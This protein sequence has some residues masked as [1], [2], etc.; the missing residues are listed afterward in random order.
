MLAAMARYVRRQAAALAA[1][2]RRRL[3]AGEVEFAAAA[4]GG[5]RM[6]SMSS[7]HAPEFSRPIELARLAR[8]RRSIEIAAEPAER[9]A[10][11]ER[12]DLLALDR[13]EAEVR[14]RRLAGEL[15]QAQRPSSPPM[16]CRPASSRWSR[17]KPASTERFTLLYG[18]GRA[19]AMRCVI[20]LDDRDRR[21][22]STDGASISARRWP[23]SSR[24]RSTPIPA[25][26]APA[27]AGTR[28]SRRRPRPSPALAAL[29]EGLT[30]LMAMVA[31]QAD[32]WLL[33][34]GPSRA[35]L[36]ACRVHSHG[37]SEEEDLEVAPQ[38]A[39]R[40]TMR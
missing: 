6:M 32:F 18:A 3:L 20:D 25:P 28:R 33:T 37:R 12:F 10:L 31:S 29:N 9:A 19:G 16:W 2:P 35:F 15:V 22:A 23:S 7:R 39:P 8:R 30:G 14:L 13:L 26:P 5:C 11:A 17:S 21:A 4:G 40:R 1:Q 38:H 27:S 24:W 36:R 34:S